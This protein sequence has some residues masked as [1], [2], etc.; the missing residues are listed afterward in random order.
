MAK[1]RQTSWLFTRVTEE[2]NSGPTRTTPACGQNRPLIPIPS[3]PYPTPG[4]V[5]F[6]KRMVNSPGLGQISGSTTP[7]WERKRRQTPHPLAMTLL[8]FSWIV[9]EMELFH[10]IN[11]W[12]TGDEIDKRPTSCLRSPP[13][14]RPRSQGYQTFWGCPRGRKMPGPRAIIKSQI[15]IK[16]RANSRLFPPGMW[17]GTAWLDWC[18]SSRV[19]LFVWLRNVD[20][21]GWQL[22]SWHRWRS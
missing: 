18:I 10:L 14:A 21:H 15:G 8:K 19:D 4:I 20:V 12:Y 17:M 9:N 22:K 5:F 6:F 16:T 7:G 1:T 11:M 3:R 2:L 13:H